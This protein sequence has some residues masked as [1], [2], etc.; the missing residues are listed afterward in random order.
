MGDDFDPKGKG[1]LLATHILQKGF[2]AGS[3]VGAIIGPLVAYRLTRK[4]EP[5]VVRKVVKA[6]GTSAVV[7]S[8]LAGTAMLRDTVS[9]ASR[10]DHKA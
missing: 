4:G 9:M 1:A 5:H 6:C 7:G 10:I 8:A 2:Q 3:L